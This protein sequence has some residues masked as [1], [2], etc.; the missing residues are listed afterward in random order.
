MR[1]WPASLLARSSTSDQAGEMLGT[2]INLLDIAQG[3]AGRVMRSRKY[4]FTQANDQAKGRAQL[5]LTMERKRLFSRLA[6]SASFRPSSASRYNWLV[7]N[8]AYPRISPDIIKCLKYASEKFSDVYVL[9]SESGEL[10]SLVNFA[11]FKLISP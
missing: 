1:S 7:R 2:Y 10:L 4:H 6:S 8:A 3:R 11:F 9:H 5:M